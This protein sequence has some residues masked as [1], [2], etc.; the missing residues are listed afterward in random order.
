QSGTIST[1]FQFDAS[2]STD[3]E[4]P[5]NEMEVRWDWNGDSIWDTGY[6]KSKIISH[7][8]TT[9]GSWLVVCEVRDG[10]GFV[11]TEAKNVYVAEGT[12]TDSRDGR[13]YAYKTI[14]TQTWMLE[15][16]AWLPKVSPTTEGSLTSPFYYVYD[17]D[18]NST[19]EAKTQSTFLTYGVLY[20]WEAAMT[21]CPPGWHLPDDEEWKTLE[22]YFLMSAPEADA[23]GMRNSGDVGGKL[24]EAGNAHW[25]S[26]NMAATNESGF[27]ALPGGLRYGAGGFDDL[28][29]RASFWTASES[30]DS[31]A[32]LRNLFQINA[33]VDRNN[34]PRTVGFSI[35]C[36]KGGSKPAAGF[37]IDPQSGT[38]STHF[39]FDASISTDPETPT[40]EMEVRWDWNGDGT[41][42]T[43]YS[44]TKT[45]SH[46][47][48]QIGS[49]SV[50]LEVKDGD[51]L[52]D[53]ET[54]TVI[55]A[56]GTVTDSRDGRAY[57]YKTIGTQTWMTENLAYLPSVSPSTAGSDAAPHYYVFGY[58]G[59][60]VDAAKANA[61]YGTC[62]VLYNWPAALAACPTGWHL[63]TDAE[64]STLTTY[65]G[66]ESVAG[67][68]MKETGTTHWQ[69]TNAGATNE[70]GFTALPGGLRDSSDS[71]FYGGGQY[72]MFWSSTVNIVGGV[73][74]RYL[75]YYNTALFLNPSY[76]M[77]G[78]SVRCLR[79]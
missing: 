61:N 42:D 47:Y 29:D 3:P 6:E 38:I 17:Y 55:V 24:K 12:V 13:V 20:N 28:G 1:H 66:G 60:S 49:Y 51:G 8:Y 14:G 78:V 9:H 25:S 39:Q 21:A 63:P 32:N 34:Y 5:T 58:E 68:K 75:S 46:Q 73:S 77:T 41:W 48:S 76:R 23:T 43:G 57:A 37:T 30:G 11:D 7:Q 26:P 45:I 53:T 36:L 15:N 10:D 72:A 70:S 52:V 31:Y 4:T 40:N 79:N 56:E 18:G 59:T 54:K 67:G 35:R 74:Y 44:E 2:I 33:G 71:T 69:S 62:G 50:I 19:E 16:L 64:W 65:L 22:K 27:T